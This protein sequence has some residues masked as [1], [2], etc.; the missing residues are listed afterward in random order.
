M[1][2]INLKM[3]MTRN[4]MF[5]AFALLMITGA[6]AQNIDQARMD[7]DLKVAENILATLSNNDNRR[8]WHE[9]N[10]EGSYVPDYGVIFSMPMQ[11][12]FVFKGQNV[13]YSGNPETVTIVGYGSDGDD[14]RDVTVVQDVMVARAKEKEEKMLKVEELKEGAEKQ[15]KEQMTTFLAD[16]ADLIGQLDPSDRIVVQIKDRREYEF[17]V[18][19]SSS[20]SPQG[21]TAEVKKSDLTAQR[22]GKISRDE[23]IERIKFTSNEK[24]EIA[25]DIELFATIF[26]R[27]YEPDLS[28]TYYLASR[29]IGYSRLDNLGVTFSMKFYSSSSDGG[30]HTIRTTGESGLTQA[31][32]NEKVNAMYPEFE[33]SFKQNLLDY[34]RTVKSLKPEEKLIFKVRLT[35]CKGCEM[36]KEIEVMVNGKTLSDYDKGSL[37]RDKAMTLVEVKK[38]N[39]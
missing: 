29:H 5:T 22:Q 19:R 35:E 1:K 11:S 23:L 2:K 17:Y 16:Y 24:K 28:S 21:L 3:K 12:S 39:N 26:S 6:K 34:G 37:S 7:R 33:K 18:G 8:Y 14:D 30:M 4:F 15:V 36:P 20:K 27:L 31:E 9:D 25:K 13:V 32:R 38:T 10:I